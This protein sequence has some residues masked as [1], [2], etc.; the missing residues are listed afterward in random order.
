MCVREDIGVSSTPRSRFIIYNIKTNVRTVEVL[1]QLSQVCF[2]IRV[3][4]TNTWNTGQLSLTS[5][6]TFQE[7][8]FFV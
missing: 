3:C 4:T 5:G 7:E 8:Y 1:P 2:H 6:P